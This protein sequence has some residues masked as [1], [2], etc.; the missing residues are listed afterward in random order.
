LRWV[1]TKTLGYRFS[2]NF[3]HSRIDATNLGLGERSGWIVSGKA[4]AD[5]QPDAA[6]LAQLTFSITG[7]RLLP[8]G[9]RKAM[10]LVNAGFRHKLNAKLW[11]FVTVQDAIHS[12]LQHDVIELPYLIEHS[13]ER[14]RT[15]AAFLGL[16]YNFG[17]KKS[18]DPAF[19]Y[20]G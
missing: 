18:H 11:A 17:K 7:D 8:Q 2:G 5:W 12:Y 10:L 15:Q 6:S 20:S 1:R 9:S 14:A 4:S 3:V 16:T 13:T 19:D